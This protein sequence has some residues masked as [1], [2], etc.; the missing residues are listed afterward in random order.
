MN[1]EQ[2]KDIEALAH[3]WIDEAEK[4]RVERE[5]AKGECD[6]GEAAFGIVFFKLAEFEFR[7]R[8]LE[9]GKKRADGFLDMHTPIG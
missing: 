7:L 8:A 4:V 9:A 2:A 3:K 5:E 6:F 1:K